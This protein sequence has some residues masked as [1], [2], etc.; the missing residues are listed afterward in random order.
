[1]NT[2]YLVYADKYEGGYGVEL[3]CIG[4][5]DSREA[6]EARANDFEYADIAVVD[7]NSTTTDVYLD[8]YRE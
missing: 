7:L 3:Y 8:G 6:A 1:M 2:L 5:F 4:I